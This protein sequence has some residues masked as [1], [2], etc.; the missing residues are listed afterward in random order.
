MNTYPLMPNFFSKR[1]FLTLSLAQQHKKAAEL[2]R[3]LYES[4]LEKKTLDKPLATRYAT[5]SDFLNLPILSHNLEDLSNRYHEHLLHAGLC[6]KEHNL[7]PQLRCKDKN[8]SSPFL[9]IDIY[10]DHI[11]SA[12]NIGS[13]IRTIEALRLGTL[14]LPSTMAAIDSKKTKDTAMGTLEKIPYKIVRGLEE[15]K[16]PII[17]LET[18]NNAL[19]LYDYVFPK[20]FSL[21]LGNEEFGL[22]KDCLQKADVILQIPLYGFK[23]SLNVACAFSLVA[24]EIRR[25]FT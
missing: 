13:I 2:L 14:C 9:P 18:C 5:L 15:I 24:G 25:Q 22:S 7:L 10:L 20:N 21:L 19:S 6:L 11:R 17:A 12:H 1:K 23:N 16:Q 3:L 4:I 8:S